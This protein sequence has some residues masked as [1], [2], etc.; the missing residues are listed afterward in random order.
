[1]ELVLKLGSESSRFRVDIFYVVHVN[2]EN[3]CLQKKKN[4]ADTQRKVKNNDHV[5]S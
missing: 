5:A 4:E 2:A 3:F 1:M